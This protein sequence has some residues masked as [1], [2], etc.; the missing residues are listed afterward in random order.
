MPVRRI[1][2]VFPFVPVLDKLVKVAKAMDLILSWS[3]ILLGD[4]ILNL[5]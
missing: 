5:I 3:M 1:S 4:L 2:N